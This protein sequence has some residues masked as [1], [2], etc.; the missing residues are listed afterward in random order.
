MISV[1]EFLLRARLDQT[2]LDTWI[3]AG[4]L[5][6]SEKDREPAFS[7][8]DLARAQLIRDL[9][10]DMGVNEEGISVILHLLDQMH[11]LR[12]SMHGVLQAM[13][14]AEQPARPTSRSPRR[15]RSRR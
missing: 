13:R 1:E 12:R 3:A 9:R 5:V 10:D 8:V 11:G 15:P 4:W 6:I 14:G 7:D 2:S